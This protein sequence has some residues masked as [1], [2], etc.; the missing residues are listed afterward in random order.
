MML[1]QHTVIDLLSRECIR[2][3]LQQNA[4]SPDSIVPAH[5]AFKATIIRL[6]LPNTL[7]RYINYCLKWLMYL[8]DLH[9]IQSGSKK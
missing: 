7:E 2:L 3:L 9:C 5:L 1:T 4:D 6:P 8:S